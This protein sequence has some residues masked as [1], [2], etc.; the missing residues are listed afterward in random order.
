MKVMN[1]KIALYSISSFVDPSFFIILVFYQR[2]LNQT[3]TTVLKFKGKLTF[4]R[5][6]ILLNDLKKRKQEFDIQ[7]VL[8]KK[9]LTLMIEVLE[10]ILKY[11]DQ[12]EDF[13]SKNPDYFP[14]FELSRI[15]LGFKLVSKNP[16]RD[17][18]MAEISQKINK[19][20]AFDEKELKNFYRET[21]TNGIFTEKGGAG[22][23]F[24]EMAKITANDLSFS[25]IPAKTGFSIFELNLYINHIDE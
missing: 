16:I 13:I 22:L 7:P 23:G 5:I 4:Q 9:L 17:E 8:Y 20:N 19:I 12:F 24:I 6:G 18:D 14:E 2:I 1:R 21:I 10:N 11:S 25:L 3:T 15:D